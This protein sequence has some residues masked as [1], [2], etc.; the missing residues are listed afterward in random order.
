MRLVVS[1]LVGDNVNVVP[2]ARFKYVSVV[3]HD[4]SLFTAQV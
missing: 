2:P 3:V 1:G 4:E